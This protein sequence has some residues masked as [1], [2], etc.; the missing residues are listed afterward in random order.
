MSCLKPLELIHQRVVLG[1]ADLRR[2]ENVIQ[3]LMA[4]QI[5]SQ[6]LDFARGARVG[7]R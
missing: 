1:I 5:V 7:H 6:F 3:M 2:V 4:A